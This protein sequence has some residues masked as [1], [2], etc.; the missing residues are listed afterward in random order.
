VIL[1][2]N[3]IETTVRRAA[4]GAGWPYGLAE[5]AG[6]AAA[7]LAARGLDGVG[8]ALA[9][10]EAGPAP[11]AAER[12][13][14]GW[15]LQG[16]RSV[17]AGPSCF[18][19]LQAGARGTSVILEDIDQPLMLVGLGGVAAA[20]RGCAYRLESGAGFHADI[21]GDAVTPTGPVPG[22][23]ATLRAV[24][25]AEAPDARPSEPVPGV[26]IDD[27]LWARVK[28]LAAK[29]YVPATEQSRARGAGA[30]EIDND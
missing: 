25:S 3:E 27:A 26:E 20:E 6:R 24:R 17:A 13:A 10:L 19:L 11:V 14:G 30:G 18:D 4:T 12:T 28:A 22:P 9:S 7:W 16:A 5:D 1:S 29:S 23:G 8:S 21:G 2:L 15:I